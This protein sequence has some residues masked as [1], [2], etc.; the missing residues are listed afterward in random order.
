MGVISEAILLFMMGT[1]SANT[2]FECHDKYREI[3]ELIAEGRSTYEKV[4]NHY[5]IPSSL[6]ASER[7]K[8]LVQ[9]LAE[10]IRKTPTSY[11][12]HQPVIELL[13][14]TTDANQ[15]CAII[16]EQKLSGSFNVIHQYVKRSDQERTHFIRVNGKTIAIPPKRPSGSR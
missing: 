12:L 2:A 8:G 11:E 14:S 1:A 9:Q 3:Q 4:P 7:D 10:K 5:F 16:E 13:R 6:I 15:G